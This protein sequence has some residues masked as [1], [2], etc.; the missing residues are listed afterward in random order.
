MKK[1][2]VGLLVKRTRGGREVH[3]FWDRQTCRHT[4]VQIRTASF[5]ELGTD[6]TT[7]K[8]KMTL[9]TLEMKKTL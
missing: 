1:D 2:A 3:N 7:P 5:A 6:Q 8:L 4:E 9:K